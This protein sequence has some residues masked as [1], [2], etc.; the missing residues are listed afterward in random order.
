MKRYLIQTHHTSSPDW[1]DEENFAGPG[2]YDFNQYSS[3]AVAMRTMDDLRYD[4]IRARL[5]ER[6]PRAAGRGRR[7]DVEET[8][9]ETV[10]TREAAPPSSRRSAPRRSSNPRE[11]F[12]FETPKGADIFMYRLRVDGFRPRREG[13]MLVVVRAPEEVTRAALNWVRSYARDRGRSDAR[14]RTRKRTASAAQEWVLEIWDRDFERW[15]WQDS[16]RTEAERRGLERTRDGILRL[17]TVPRE[18]I[19]IRK[20]AARRR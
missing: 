20:R 17:G 6:R 1:I 16:A 18:N 5:I 9:T 7:D 8:T 11:R 14:S 10:T 19:R 15:A 12:V 2:W 4:G 3:G 13:P